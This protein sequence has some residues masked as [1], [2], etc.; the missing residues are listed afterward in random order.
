MAVLA[1][2]SAPERARSVSTD[3]LLTALSGGFELEQRLAFRE[4]LYDQLQ[5]R[6]S[7]FES[8]RAQGLV[9]QRIELPADADA[10]E[11]PIVGRWKC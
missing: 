5:I 7:V 11:I 2:V 9:R 3:A 1:N 8:K 10:K 6:A 4:K